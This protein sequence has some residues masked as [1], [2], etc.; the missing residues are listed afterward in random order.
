MCGAPKAAAAAAAAC[1][2]LGLGLV[3]CT[4]VM[5]DSAQGRAGF[6]AGGQEFGYATVRPSAHL[7][8]WLYYAGGGDAPAGRPLVVW[9]EGG[10]GAS[11]TSYGNFGKLGPMDPDGRPRAASWVH[12]VNLLFVDSPV[13]TGFSYVDDDAALAHNNC[14]TSQDLVA[15]M[16]HFLYKYPQFAATPV[17][18]FGESYGGKVAA[19]FALDLYKEMESGQLA[20]NLKGVVMGDSWLSG[21]DH[22]ESWAPYLHNMGMVDARGRDRLAEAAARVRAA[23][24]SAQWLYAATLWSAA[25]E[26]MTNVTEGVNIYHVLA[27][28]KADGGE[29]GKPVVPCASS[30]MMNGAVRRALGVIPDAVRH[31]NDNSRVFSA[32]YAEFMVPATE[33][34]ERL[35]NETGLEV[36]V[37]AGQCDVFTNMVG[38]MAWVD[39][40]EWPLATVF[41][42]A[43]RTRLEVGGVIAGVLKEAGNLTTLWVHRAGHLVANDY[44]E[45]AAAILRLATKCGPPLEPQPPAQ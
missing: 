18:I 7:F 16:R 4:W 28:I 8:Y 39:R 35:L 36:T 3:L 43:P 42:A 38:T 6:G 14:Q 33:P 15:M 1:L 24:D 2:R 10:P 30:E 17:Y 13:G 19:Q 26:L 31:A 27:P 9:L 5:T 40:L 22:V 41:R 11:A 12:S 44:P 34:V 23:A 20:V 32:Q 45:A 37:Y 29:S 25:W 21:V